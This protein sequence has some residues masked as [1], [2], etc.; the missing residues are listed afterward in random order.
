MKL[1]YNADSNFIL[2]GVYRPP[3]APFDKFD[4]CLCI[5]QEFIDSVVGTPELHITGDFNLPFI[6]WS[7]RSTKPG[8]N[9]TSS[10]RSSEL[11]LLE[12]MSSNFLE[13]IVN[14]PTRNDQNILD[15]ILSKNTDL[16][17]SVSVYKTEK[18]DHDI[19]YCTLL[20]PQFML[21]QV[22]TPQFTPS[23]ELDDINFNS[24]DWEAINRDLLSRIGLQSSTHRHI[25]KMLGTCLK[26]SSW[27]CVRST[28]PHTATIAKSLYHQR[29]RNQEELYSGKRSDSTPGLTASSTSPRALL[30]LATVPN[31]AS[32]MTSGLP[33]SCL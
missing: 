24:A 10:D 14:E 33:L 19:V 18:S 3:S 11:A 22:A 27:M 29:S 7:T 23:S 2:A 4:E 8:T 15:L 30:L 1:R 32:S 5:I 16:I 13:Q 26:A 6:D 31:S 25:K 9:I 12:F 17:H 20:H 21:N 28:P